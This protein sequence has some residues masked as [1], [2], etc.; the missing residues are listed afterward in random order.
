VWVEFFRFEGDDIFDDLCDIPGNP[1]GQLDPQPPSY[2]DEPQAYQDLLLQQSRLG[3]G[4]MEL[5]TPIGQLQYS[6]GSMS[7][8]P[9]TNQGKN[10]T[11]ILQVLYF[12]KEIPTSLSQ[13]FS[14]IR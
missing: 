7:G 14:D 8:N 2:L 4:K 12:R 6:L 3:V 11:S 9:G 1:H 5:V 10:V 13:Q